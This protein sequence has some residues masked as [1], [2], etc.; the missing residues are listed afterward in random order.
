MGRG[1]VLGVTTAPSQRAAGAPALPN[2]GGSLS[3]TTLFK[4]EQP[5]WGE[6]THYGD[7]LVLGGQPSLFL[8]TENA[9]FIAASLLS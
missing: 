4:E 2:F 9:I 7:G 8:V 1:L 3:T 6:V 5:N